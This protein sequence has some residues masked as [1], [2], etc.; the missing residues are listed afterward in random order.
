MR[1]AMD[2]RQTF[3]T[4]DYV[5]IGAGSAGCVLANRLTEDASIK[6]LLLEAG[7]EDDWRWIH[8]PIGQ[9]YCIGNPRTDWR[10]MTEPEP[11]LNGRKTPV[12]RGRVLG[13]SSSINGMVYMRGQARDYDGWRQMGNVGWAWDDVLPYFKKSEDFA[14]GADGAHGA[15][16]PLRVEES[17]VRWDV[18]DGLQKASAEVG[19]APCNDFNRGNNEGCGYVQVTQRRSRRWSAATAFLKP[20]RPRPNLTVLTAAHTTAIRFDG[21]RATGVE[22][23]RDGQP[24][25]AVATGEVILAAGAIASPQVLQLSGVGP[26]ALLREH[27]VTVRHD[28]PGVGDNL[29]DHLNVRTI[30]KLTRGDTFNMRYHNP[31]KKFLMGA[32]YFLLKRG[33]LVLGSPPMSGFARSDPSRETPNIQY[34]MMTITFDKLGDPPHKFPAVASNICNLRPRSRGHVRIKSADPHV[35]PAVLH[36]YLMDA[37]DQRVAVDSIKL[38]RRIVASPAFQPFGPQDH[39][40]PAHFTSDAQLLEHARNF[41]L[42]VFHPVGTCRMGSDAT[43]VVDDRLR[44]R[45]LAGLRVVDASVMPAITS[46]NTNAPT[47]MIAE[48]AS[49]M[50]K[51]DR[52]AGA[53][54]AAA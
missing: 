45:G 31:L 47:I 13:G 14:H 35:Y 15:G 1:K 32:E 8:I 21:R 18:L 33:P 43:A 52:K 20:A 24:L 50:I 6:V 11:G 10:Y 40:P 19:I 9:Y 39:M 23:V 12:P 53:V 44:V 46:G 30:W 27:G 7:G 26:A 5:V 38:M 22:F 34:Q 2:Q 54:G 51:A 17:R 49:D 36:N 41:G 37:D 3:G 48:K 28:I 16:G 25:F 4:F 42:T 29:Q